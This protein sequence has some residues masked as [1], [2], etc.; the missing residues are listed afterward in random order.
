MTKKREEISGGGGGGLI[1]GC[2][3][4]FHFSK[5]EQTTWWLIDI[6]WYTEE[7]G[8][9]VLSH[10]FFTVFRFVC[11]LQAYE[12]T[13]VLQTTDSYVIAEQMALIDYRLVAAVSNW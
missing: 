5:T 11:D 3:F 8:K 4:D 6:D 13:H 7:R 1:R 9:N 10:F 12:K 2:N